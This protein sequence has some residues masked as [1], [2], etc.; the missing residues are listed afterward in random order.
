MVIP[1]IDLESVIQLS[2][3]PTSTFEV[4][5]FSCKILQYVVLTEHGKFKLLKVLLSMQYSAMQ[6]NMQMLQLNVIKY[7]LPGLNIELR[8]FRCGPS[9]AVYIPAMVSES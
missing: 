5:I 2:C 4:R 8:D 1:L 6:V 7:C 3:F 9:T